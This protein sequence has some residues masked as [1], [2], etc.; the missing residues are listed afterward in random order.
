MQDMIIGGLVVVGTCLAI[1]VAAVLLIVFRP[2]ARR[3]RK[4]H[5]RRPKIDLFA[6]RSGGEGE[7]PPA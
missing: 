1:A 7:K 6:E 2:S 3:R 5:S 4:R